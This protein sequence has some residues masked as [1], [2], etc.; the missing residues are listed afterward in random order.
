MKKIATVSPY[1]PLILAGVLALGLL[2]S[3]SGDHDVLAPENSPAKAADFENSGTLKLSLINNPVD[4]DDFIL[5]IRGISAHRASGDSLDGW[6]KMEIEPT[7][8]HLLD[9]TN[10]VSALLAE[11]GLPA[12]TYNQIRLLLA[13]GNRIVVDGQEFDLFI[14]SG[15]T[16]GIKIHHVF[17][18][19]EGQEYSATL[20]FD[21]DRSVKYNGRGRY[22]LKPVIRVQED[23]S[24]GSIIGII[25]P[26]EAETYVWTLVGT[27]TVSTYPDAVSGE[28]ILA[29]LP[30]G[31]Y[32]INLKPTAPGP[33]MPIALTG[34]EVTAGNITDIGTFDMM[35]PV[36]QDRH[37]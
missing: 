14:P 18:I 3:C 27:D 9:L 13:E 34:V 28:F 29:S 10:G 31:A 30:A 23:T 6:F 17:E 2:V 26:V 1:I 37:G 20:D 25:I 36:K 7:E 16:S 12:G 5:V 11:M 15:L 21:A 4:F 35:V 33:W 8:Y 22:S 32:T 24:A 19:I